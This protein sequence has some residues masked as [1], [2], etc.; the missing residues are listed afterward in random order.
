MFSKQQKDEKK[1]NE[2]STIIGADT[3]VEGTLQIE[4][5]IRIDGKVLGEIKC[6]GDVTIGK[7]GYVE[8]SISARNL[9]IAGEV[10]GN[11]NIEEK[12]HIFETG[13]LNGTAEMKT[14]IIEENGY[15][16]GESF[17]KTNQPDGKEN[18]VSISKEQANES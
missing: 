8:H 1:V 2:L 17:M 6:T 18:V 4:S 16:R 12:I 7:G 3:I 5:S 15:F 9:L 13:R 11:V 14:I 10:K